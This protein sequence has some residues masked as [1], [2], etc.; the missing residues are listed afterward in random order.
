MPQKTTTHH[1]TINWVYSAGES[2]AL[3]PIDQSKLLQLIAPP[4]LLC[5]HSS[6]GQAHRTLRHNRVQIID[7]GHHHKQMEGTVPGIYYTLESQGRCYLHTASRQLSQRI[8]F[9]I[10]S[11]SLHLIFVHSNKCNCPRTNLGLLCLRWV[12][13]NAR[14]R[15]TRGSDNFIRTQQRQLCAS[16]ASLK[17]PPQGVIWWNVGFFF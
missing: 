11:S 17:T 3:Y 14:P 10:A 12:C 15:S 8:F 5:L 7:L 4:L 2:G 1:R 9:I 16:P 6:P 13:P